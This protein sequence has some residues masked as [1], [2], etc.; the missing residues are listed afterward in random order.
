MLNTFRPSKQFQKITASGQLRRTQLERRNENLATLATSKSRL[1]IPNAISQSDAFLRERS[2][3]N[4]ETAVSHRVKTHAALHLTAYLSVAPSSL[5]LMPEM[6]YAAP[7]VPGSLM[8]TRTF[9]ANA[10]APVRV[11]FV[12]A[13]PATD[14]RS[15]PLH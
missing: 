3:V 7:G 2:Q 4:F 8:I 5:T 12:K 10:D 15:H 13:F 9:F 14:L 11:V 6:P 1:I